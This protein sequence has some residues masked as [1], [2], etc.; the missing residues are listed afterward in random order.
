MTVRFLYTKLSSYKKAV[1]KTGSPKPNV[2]HY[3]TTDGKDYAA[4]LIAA[5]KECHF[6]DEQLLGSRYLTAKI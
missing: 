4:C 1:T 2:T 5:K 3:V 6:K